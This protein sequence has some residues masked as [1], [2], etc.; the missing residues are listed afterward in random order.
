MSDIQK[1]L[2]HIALRKRDEKGEEGVRVSEKSFVEWQ[3]ADEIERLQQREMQALGWMYAQACCYI[4]AG[5]DIR[6]VEVPELLDRYKREANKLVD[7]TRREQ[8][9]PD[10]YEKWKATQ[11]ALND[12]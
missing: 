7:E 6:T 5:V 3:A 10:A 12:G 9:N 1:Q 11:E 4:D 8:T 2:R